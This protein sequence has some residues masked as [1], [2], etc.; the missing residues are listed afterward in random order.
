MEYSERSTY[1]TLKYIEFITVTTKSSLLTHHLAAFLKR[2]VFD[3]IAFR[4]PESGTTAFLKSKTPSE[5]ESCIEEL[6]KAFKLDVELY[7]DSEIQDSHELTTQEHLLLQEDV[8]KI[9]EEIAKLENELKHEQML[10]ETSILNGHISEGEGEQEEANEVKDEGD[11]LSGISDCED[12]DKLIVR[13][14]SNFLNDALDLNSKSST[15]LQDQNNIA[16]SLMNSSDCDMFLTTKVESYDGVESIAEESIVAEQFDASEFDAPQNHNSEGP[17]E[18]NSVSNS[19]NNFN[20]SNYQFSSNK[21]SLRA[22]NSKIFQEKLASHKQDATIDV[23]EH[24]SANLKDGNIM[25]EDKDDGDDVIP[26]SIPFDIDLAKT[27]KSRNTNG[28]H[29]G[30]NNNIS[31]NN[32]HDNNNN[33]DNNDKLVKICIENNHVDTGRNANIRNI[34]TELTKQNEAAKLDYLDKITSGY[35][36]SRSGFNFDSYAANTCLLTQDEDLFISCAAALKSM[37]PSNDH[38]SIIPSNDQQSIIPSNDH[39]S[40]LRHHHHPAIGSDSTHSTIHVPKNSHAATEENNCKIINNENNLEGNANVVTESTIGA[41]IFSQEK[42][43]VSGNDGV[44]IAGDGVEYLRENNAMT[45]DQMEVVE[46]AGSECIDAD[47]M[48]VEVQ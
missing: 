26:S 22:E 6:A 38:H 11:N 43:N 24:G 13:D 1:R 36:N 5:L 29:N 2:C 41:Y 37:I 21:E 33:C 28:G 3:R 17:I 4:R 20:L 25:N 35:T 7:N 47:T 18:A 14:T 42:L 34:I 23:N 32:V 10:A 27:H 19:S 44:E 15:S 45:N 40:F 12:D 8:E 48:D 39:Q 16:C 9:E 46:S 30:N 31:D